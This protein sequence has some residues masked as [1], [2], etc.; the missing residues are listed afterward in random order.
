MADADAK[1][2][3]RPQDDKRQRK[4]RWIGR[5]CL[6]VVLLFGAPLA[7]IQYRLWRRESAI[8]V[9]TD[10]GAKVAV[11]HNP[12]P[13]WAMKVTSHLPS[14]CGNTLSMPHYFVSQHHGAWTAE[15]WIAL[16]E[17]TPVIALDLRGTAVRDADLAHVRSLEGINSL[18]LAGAG[19]TDEGVEHL[20]GL[21]FTRL[22][23]ENNRITAK[24]LPVIETIQTPKEISIG[25][26]WQFW[27]SVDAEALGLVNV[28]ER[29]FSTSEYGPKWL[30]WTAESV[31]ERCSIQGAVALE[32]HGCESA[33][34]LVWLAEAK[35]VK[36][37]SY[38][39]DGNWH[40]EDDVVER[41]DSVIATGCNVQ[42]FPT[43][44]TLPPL[45]P[46]VLLSRPTSY[47]VALTIGDTRLLGVVYDPQQPSRR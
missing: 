4:R 17:L 2:E 47:F 18:D 46:V 33:A 26:P 19:I 3:R 43:G 44:E 9:L 30:R 16:R 25:R 34:G 1:F 14:W 45:S 37:T 32:N 15:Q 41:Q 42:M 39:A 12:Y 8:R 10:A 35:V 40:F 29:R 11:W 24:S 28:G 22:Q 13:T 6:A 21:R 20:R 38:D 27:I 5:I 36:G 31:D 23:L 7:L